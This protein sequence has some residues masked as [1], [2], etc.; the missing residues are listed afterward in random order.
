M[1]VADDTSTG[2]VYVLTW[3]SNVAK[4]LSFIVNFALKNALWKET[5]KH[6]MR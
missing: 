6:I 5:W 2:L 3:S 4:N 1:D